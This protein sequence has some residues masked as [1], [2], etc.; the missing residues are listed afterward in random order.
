MRFFAFSSV[1]AVSMGVLSTAVVLTAV[2]ARAADKPAKTA[3]VAEQMIQK[4]DKNGDKALDATELSAA[5]AEHREQ[6]AKKMGKPVKATKGPTPEAPSNAS[7][8]TATASW[9]PRN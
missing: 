1:A 9:M 8:P 3:G 7:T 5:M 2:A 4:F 6:H